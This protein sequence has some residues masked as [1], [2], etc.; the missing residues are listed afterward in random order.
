MAF[1][2]HGFLILYSYLGKILS[3]VSS[4][5]SQKVSPSVILSSHM[6]SLASRVLILNA[7]ACSGV[8]AA[9]CLR[10]DIK[11]RPFSHGVFFVDYVP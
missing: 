10:R 8:M 6:L 5:F 3:A 9:Y 2:I 4:A 1:V 7:Y 11:A